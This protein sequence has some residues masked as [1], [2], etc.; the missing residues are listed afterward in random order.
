MTYGAP[1]WPK[2]RKGYQ[3]THITF[4]PDGSVRSSIFERV[5]RSRLNPATDREAPVSRRGVRQETLFD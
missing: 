5:G 1:R 2:P 3:L 4:R